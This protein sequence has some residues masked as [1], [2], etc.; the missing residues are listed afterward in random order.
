MIKL[1]KEFTC[2]FC[3]YGISEL[4][5]NLQEIKEKVINIYLYKCNFCLESFTTT[6]SDEEWYQRYLDMVI[7][8]D[9]EN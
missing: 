4:T 9:D 8:D 6:E 1:K 5:S 3:E 2:P 7:E